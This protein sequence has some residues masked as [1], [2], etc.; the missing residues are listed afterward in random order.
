MRST[1]LH[2]F[3]ALRSAGLLAAL[4]LA[5]AL[6]LRGQSTATIGHSP[7]AD[8][9]GT[10]SS[11]FATIGRSDIYVPFRIN[12]LGDY[13][14]SSVALL[15]NGTGSVGGLTLLAT[16]ALGTD[17]GTPGSSLATFTGSG[18]LGATPTVFTF[19]AGSSATLT[20]NTTYYLYLG[21]DSASSVNWIRT[22][23]ASAGGA[24]SGS[25]TV[26]GGTT[27]NPTFGTLAATDTVSFRSFQSN[28][29]GVTI[30]DQSQSNFAGFSITAS[31]VSAIPE[32]STY[33][34][35]GGAA[36]LVVAL[37]VRRRRA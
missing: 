24:G 14:L 34:A 22:S 13:T 1:T 11:L 15:L 8:A 3:R 9:A 33:A 7:I 29:G 17:P 5:A 28:S 19:N 30:V 27:L 25:G 37:I 23:I 18:T 16:T 4:A 2:S 36:A 10:N 31:A 21:F 20:A 12:T 26:S 35:L 6:P 32:P